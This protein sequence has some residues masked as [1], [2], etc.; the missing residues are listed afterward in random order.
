MSISL[1][2]AVKLSLEHCAHL[3]IDAD[4]MAAAMLRE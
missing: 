2:K 4:E 3:G 1:A